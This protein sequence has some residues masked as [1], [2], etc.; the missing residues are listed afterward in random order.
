MILLMLRT[1]PLRKT[2]ATTS[3]RYPRDRN[4]ALI[5]RAIHGLQTFRFIA[6]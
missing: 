5:S 3:Q 4:L 2:S 6:T 1:V